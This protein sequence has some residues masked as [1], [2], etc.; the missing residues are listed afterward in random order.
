[1]KTPQQAADSIR[2][3]AKLFRDMGECVEALE[4]VGSLDNAVDE[5]N[6]A[7]AKLDAKANSLLALV[8][9]QQ[10]KIDEAEEYADNLKKIAKESADAVIVSAKSEREK[11][12]KDAQ[13]KA[14][15]VELDTKLK[16]E[17]MLIGPKEM[18]AQFTRE[19]DTLYA[20]SLELQDA[21]NTKKDELE[22][23]NEAIIN[24]R[25]SVSSILN[26]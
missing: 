23:L 11:I 8:S 18:V 13:D 3:L 6:Q 2:N 10:S 17:Q 15:Q 7:I 14:G 9:S 5:R 25:K 22:K 1:M 12:I 24:A 16:A 20:Q 4:A 21:I 19:R 26:F